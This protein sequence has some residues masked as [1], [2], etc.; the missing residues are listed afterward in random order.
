MQNPSTLIPSLSEY[1]ELIL[2]KNT[3]LPELSKF[4]KWTAEVNGSTLIA[5]SVLKPWRTNKMATK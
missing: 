3:P 4:T 1:E 2:L 5:Y